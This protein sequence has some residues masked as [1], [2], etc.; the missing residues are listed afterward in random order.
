MNIRLHEKLTDA[1]ARISRTTVIWSEIPLY[2]G[3]VMYRHSPT[4]SIVVMNA[5]AAFRD[6]HKGYSGSYLGLWMLYPSFRVR[7]KSTFRAGGSYATLVGLARL[8]DHIVCNTCL[9]ATGLCFSWVDPLPRFVTP[10]HRSH[11]VQYASLYLGRPVKG[12][13]VRRLRLIHLLYLPLF[14]LCHA[15]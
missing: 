13:I 8:T 9:V 7:Y 14:V 4:G 2:M 5:A 11:R 15:Q 3:I 6:S 10:T 12:L 1:Q